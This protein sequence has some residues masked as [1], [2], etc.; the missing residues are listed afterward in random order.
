[1]SY[2]TLDDLEKRI[3]P[4]TLVELADDDGD[5]AADAEVVA[6]ALADADAAI[7]SYLSARYATPLASARPT[8]RAEAKR[9]PSRPRRWRA[10]E[11]YP[12][13]NRR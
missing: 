2:A 11:E 7:D 6:A 8:A 13:A 4:Q 12:I 3:A 5:G 9:R 10:F 1:M